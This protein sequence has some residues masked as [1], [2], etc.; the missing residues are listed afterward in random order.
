M[1]RRRHMEQTNSIYLQLAGRCHEPTLAFW[2]P[3]ISAEPFPSSSRGSAVHMSYGS[4]LWTKRELPLLSTVN[5]YC[6]GFHYAPPPKRSIQVLTPGTWECDLFWKWGLCRCNQ[7]KVRPYWIRVGTKSNDWCLIR[8]R[9]GRF[10]HRDTVE[11]QGWCDDG[12]SHWNDAATSQGMQR[13]A[14]NHLKLGHRHETFFLKAFRRNQHCQH[15]GF[16][17]LC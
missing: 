6:K 12:G 17:L 5:T 8:G 13:I 3:A 10:G 15:L 7:V 16:G 9:R 11:T 2:V 4:M 14:G 1:C